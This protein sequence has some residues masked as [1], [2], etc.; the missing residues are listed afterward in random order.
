[1]KLVEWDEGIPALDVVL[2]EAEKARRVADGALCGRGALGALGDRGQRGE[3]EA[4]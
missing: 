1:V 2:A 3:R 4:A